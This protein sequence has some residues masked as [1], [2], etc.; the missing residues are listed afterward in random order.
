MSETRPVIMG[1]RGCLASSNYLATAAG[2]EV[3][4][5]GGNAADVAVATGLA[6]HVVEPHMNGIGG[7]NPVI[8]Y[9][10]KERKVFTIS[11]QGTAPKAATIDYFHKNGIDLIPG[12]GYLPATVPAS[13]DTWV[14]LLSHFGKMTLAEV[15]GPAIRLAEEGF[16]VYPPLRMK[17]KQ[18]EQRFREEWTTTARVFLPNGRV[19]LVGQVLKQ[20]DLARTLRSLTHAEKRSG[21][22]RLRGLDAARAFFYDGPVARRIVQFASTHASSDATGKSHT[23]LLSLQDF[24]DYKTKVEESVNVDYQ[25]LTVHK[26]GPWSQGPVFLQQLRLLEEF[27][28][29]E[30][31]HNSAD[32]IHLITEA[33]KLAFADRERFYGDPLFTKVPMAKLLSREYANARRKL[34]DMEN[35]S[36]ELRAGDGN[37]LKPGI[38]ARTTSSAGDTTHLDVVDCDGNMVTATPSG[39]WIWSSPVI[40]GLGFPLGTRGQMFSLNPDHP[41]ALAPGKRPRTTLSPTLVTSKGRPWL[42]FGTPGGDQQDQWTLQFFLNVVNFGMNLQAAIDAP[43]FHTAHFPGSF[44]PR[45]SLP[46]SLYVEDRIPSEIRTELKRRGHKIF[47]EDG[48]SNGRVTAVQYDWQNRVMKAA[49]SSRFQTA[50]ALGT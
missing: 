42:A 41:N 8:L 11:G 46:G 17:I 35:A 31:G 6:L 28:L 40:E 49:A 23:G 48:W 47:V 45:E 19:P 27:N 10:A 14:T 15:A 12:D 16:P 37:V 9:S 26:C 34:V 33:S 7:E 21:A 50:Y 4:L 5:A 29:G 1:T 36:M 32:Y 13:F 30:I 43:S 39:G 18:H 22:T 24:K 2:F 25:G 44:Y 20:K 3:L 38:D